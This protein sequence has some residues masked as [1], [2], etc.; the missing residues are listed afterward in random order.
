MNLSRTIIS[1]GKLDKQQKEA[2]W[3][4]SV[5]GSQ[6]WMLI[7]EPYNLLRDK[8][9]VERIHPSKYDFFNTSKGKSIGAN[10]MSAGTLYESTVFQEVLQHIPNAVSEDIC[11]QTILTIDNIQK[12]WRITATPDWVVWNQEKTIALQFGDIKCSTS[13]DDMSVMSERYYYQLLHNGYVLNCMN[14]ELD[15]KNQI[16]R[17][18][19]R[20]LFELTQQD[21]DWYQ[22]KLI[23][24]FVALETN[25]VEYY[26]SLYLNNNN[27]QE[28]EE[29][30]EVVYQTLN[31]DTIEYDIANKLIDLKANQAQIKEQIDELEEQ[32]KQRFDNAILQADE[33]RIFIKTTKTKGNIDYS[34]LLKH[35]KQE[36][37][38]PSDIEEQFRKASYTKKSIT[39]K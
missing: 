38:V 18:L 37:K 31:K 13:A 17:P 16:T 19:N 35:I 4:T 30:S 26:D 36:Y 5:S 34:N 28:K 10:A 2:T 9:G 33:T 6:A 12:D 29:E 24:F 11:Y 22:Q 39:I 1:L 7:N 23:E 15:T 14:T 20:Y 8:L 21:L 25:N 3:S 32:L 27:K